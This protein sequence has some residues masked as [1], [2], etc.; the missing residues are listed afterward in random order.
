VLCSPET[1]AAAALTGRITDPRDLPDLLGVDHPQLDLP[2]SSSVNTAMLEPPPPPEQA[3][4]IE[5]VKAPSIGSLPEF[6]P[7]PTP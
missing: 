5:L 3:R 2:A 1:A 7:L 6:D 4:R